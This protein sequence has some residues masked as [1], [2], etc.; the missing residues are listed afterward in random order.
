MHKLLM[1][2]AMLT[3]PRG[4]AGHGAANTALILWNGANP[5]ATC[6]DGNRNRR[7]FPRLVKSRRD[8]YFVQQRFNRETTPNGITENN[9]NITN[10]TNTAQVL[11]DH[12]RR[13]RL[14]WIGGGLRSDRPRS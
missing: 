10:T 4:Y 11:H 9:V 13:K 2:T 14:L 3:A 8:R 7:R 6:G 12:R 5:R 1:T